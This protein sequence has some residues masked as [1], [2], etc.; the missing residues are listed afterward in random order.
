MTETPSKAEKLGIFG[1]LVGGMNALGTVWIIGLMLLINSDILARGA[2]NAPI[3]GV[4]E[5]VSFSI[6]GIVSPTLYA[7]VP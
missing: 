3:A 5:L 7:P 4:A 6:V 1:R 2:L